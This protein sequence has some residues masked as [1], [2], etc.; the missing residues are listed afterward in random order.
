[1]FIPAG[2]QD[3]LTIICQWV[4]MDDYQSLN[5]S[6][7][8]VLCNVQLCATSILTLDRKTSSLSFCID[9][10]GRNKFSCRF[11]CHSIDTQK[12]RSPPDGNKAISV[13]QQFSQDGTGIS[14]WSKRNSYLK[15]VMDNGGISSE[16]L[17]LVFILRLFD[18]FDIPLGMQIIELKTTQKI[19]KLF[20]S[21]SP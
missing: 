15:W 21:F 4:G 19:Q 16:A 10:I 6:P 1:M 17:Q 8:L 18:D 11:P 14:Q 13:I 2:C 5:I 9:C 7:V 20:C 3:G 12:L